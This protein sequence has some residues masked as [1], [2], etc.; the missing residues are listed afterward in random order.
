MRYRPVCRPSPLPEN[1][2]RRF[3]TQMPTF[4]E[5]VREVREREKEKDRRAAA[6]RETRH[7]EK[8]KTAAHGFN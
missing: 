6:C 2:Y 8:E 7:A 5:K 4:E 3:F 1:P